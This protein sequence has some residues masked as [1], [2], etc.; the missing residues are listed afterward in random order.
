MGRAVKEKWLMLLFVFMFSNVCSAAMLGDTNG[1][2]KVDLAEALY[3]LQV[4]AG[5]NQTSALGDVN[6]D[7]EID[8]IEVIHALRITA[9]NTPPCYSNN[10]ILCSTSSDCTDAGGYWWSNNAC[11]SVPVDNPAPVFDYDADFASVQTLNNYVV[12]SYQD[13]ATQLASILDDKDSSI[14]YLKIFEAS[15]L[16]HSFGKTIVKLEPKS[17]MKVPSNAPIGEQRSMIIKPQSGELNY[18]AYTLKGDLNGD[19]I[20]DLNDL[21]VLNDAIVDDYYADVYDV[22]ND[23]KVDLKDV[24]FVTA[25]LLTEIK[26]YN[27]YTTDGEKLNTPT[28]DVTMPKKILL[29]MAMNLSW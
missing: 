11:S 19:S 29:M 12:N 28:R 18:S 7:G 5:G 2:G 15:L 22:N 4:S 16:S 21:N 9:G 13:I 26:Y 3:A 10:P 1:D 27:F 17:E 25:R 23:Q 24:V 8:L 14:A 6:G 20:V